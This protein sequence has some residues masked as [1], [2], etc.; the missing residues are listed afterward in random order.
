TKGAV[1]SGLA[2]SITAV[3][4]GFYRCSITFTASS[5]ALLYHFGLATADNA[6]DYVA[7]GRSVYE[8]GQQ[9][10]VGALTA[11]Q[12]NL[13]PCLDLDVIADQSVVSPGAQIGYQVNL[14]NDASVA[15]ASTT[16]TDNLPNAAG[17]NWSLSPS[18][19]GCSITVTAPQ[20]LSC[21][22][23]TFNA[24]AATV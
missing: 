23:G 9:M 12:A 20:Q 3:A 14:K 10:E 15:G 13:S 16:L 7:N 17:M 19:T 22:F 18:V 11:Y 24:G 5:S 4:P 8:W 1:D 6:S 21:N 2:S